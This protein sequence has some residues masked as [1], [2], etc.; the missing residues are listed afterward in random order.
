MTT[1]SQSSSNGHTK[2]GLLFAVILVV[3]S[4]ISMIVILPPKFSF[5]WILLPLL[6]LGGSHYGIAMISWLR[7][8]FEVSISI[9]T[10]LIQLCDTT[11]SSPTMKEVKPTEI[12][13]IV[14]NAESSS[15]L[16][17]LN[18]NTLTISGLLMLKHEEIFSA[19]EHHHPHI[20]R[21]KLL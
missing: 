11:T 7:K 17:L 3:G 14:Y 18:G 5:E 9:S 6:F 10:D 2:M 13:E 8:P 21:T 12:Y 20:K 16:K 19:L 4:L 1:I 15:F